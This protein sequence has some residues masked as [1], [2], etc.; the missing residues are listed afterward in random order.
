MSNASYVINDIVWRM[1]H[2]T[3]KH[4]L[5][6]P[7]L[8]KKISYE[9]LCLPLSSKIVSLYYNLLISVQYC[10]TLTI[11]DLLLPSLAPAM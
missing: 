5:I 11:L 10:K 2:L 4:K 9:V 1:M 8:T 3:L 6:D 7:I